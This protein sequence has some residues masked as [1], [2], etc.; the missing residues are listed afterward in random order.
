MYKFALSALAL[1]AVAMSSAQALM[2][3][4]IPASVTSFYAPGGA[5]DQAGNIITRLI[6]DDLDLVD[7]FAGQQITGF[8]FTLVNANTTQVSFRPRVRFYGLPG[9]TG[10]QLGNVLAGFTFSPVTMAANSA[11]T[12]TAT[13]GPGLNVPADYFLWAGFTFDNNL[14]A[15]GATAAQLDN[16]GWAISSPTVGSSD[17]IFFQTTTAGSFFAN[18]PTGSYFNFGGNPAANFAFSITA[19]PEPASMIALG[20]GLLAML[21]R[22]RAA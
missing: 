5:T 2:Y 10:T 12:F 8:S 22:R 9:T 6:A 18:N 11:T 19:V 15:T 13:I 4:S 20:A 7:A 3:D 14:G 1:G 21:R 17:D 16:I